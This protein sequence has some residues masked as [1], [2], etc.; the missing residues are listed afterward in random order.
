MIVINEKYCCYVERGQQH[1]QVEQQLH[2]RLLAVAL[3]PTHES[4]QSQQQPAVQKNEKGCGF[5]VKPG[6]IGD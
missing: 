1:C 3:P 4:H 6:L 2:H 5:H